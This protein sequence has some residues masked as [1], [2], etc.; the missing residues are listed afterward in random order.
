MS[1][2]DASSLF[3]AIAMPLKIHPA[4]AVLDRFDYSNGKSYC[5][6]F[7]SACIETRT[8]RIEKDLIVALTRR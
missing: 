1:T 4:T 3:K 5:T 8:V 2:K 7:A 6:D